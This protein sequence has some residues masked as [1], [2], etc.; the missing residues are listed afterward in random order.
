[1]QKATDD[2]IRLPEPRMDIRRDEF[3]QSGR[4]TGRC[5]HDTGRRTNDHVNALV[6]RAHGIRQEIGEIA[7][8]VT[9]SL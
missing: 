7:A 5:R 3:L 4:V 1:M 9:R 6:G 2:G 8:H